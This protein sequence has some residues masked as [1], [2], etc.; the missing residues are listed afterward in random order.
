MLARDIMSSNVVTI[1]E[2][3][4]INEARKLMKLHSIKKMF[5]TKNDVLVGLI[6]LFDIII[7]LFKVMDI[8]K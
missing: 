1:E 4:N 3:E 7:A 2:G 6:T 5:V 8:V